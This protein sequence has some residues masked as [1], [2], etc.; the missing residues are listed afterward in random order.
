[1]VTLNTFDPGMPGIPSRPST[2]GKPLKK[3][4]DCMSGI[5]VFVSGIFGICVNYIYS[6]VFLIALK[7]N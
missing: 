1:M 3:K 2:P 7:E 5:Y 4:W 6:L